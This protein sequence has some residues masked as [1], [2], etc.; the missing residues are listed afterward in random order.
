MLKLDQLNSTAQLDT[1]KHVGSNQ[2]CLP[3]SVACRCKKPH[4]SHQSKSIGDCYIS[5]NL[6]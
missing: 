2:T 4:S 1:A 5:L 6:L 3:F